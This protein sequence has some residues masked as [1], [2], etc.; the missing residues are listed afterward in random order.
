V[1][2]RRIEPA[3]MRGPEPDRRGG[4]RP[5]PNSPY[6]G[7][8]T[9]N[10]PTEYIERHP[11]TTVQRVAPVQRPPAPP[12]APG[13]PGSSRPQT[14]ATPGHPG[15]PAQR[16]P[17]APAAPAAAEQFLPDPDEQAE[18]APGRRGSHRPPRQS[19]GRLAATAVFV[20]ALVVVGYQAGRRQLWEDEYSSW[21]ASTFGMRDFQWLLDNKDLAL[22][23]FYAF[24]HLWIVVFGDS[25][26]SLRVP[27]VIA[28]ALTAGLL[29]LIGRRILNPVA[30]IAAGVLFAATPTISRYAQESRPYA[31][32]VF[33][34]T[35]ATLLLLRALEN[36]TWARWLIYGLCMVLVGLSHIVAITILGA[37][38]LAVRRAVRTTDV[39]RYWRWLAALIMVIWTIGPFAQYASRQSQ[40]ISWIVVN[41]KT[42][43]HLPLD[44]FGSWLVA[45]AVT[46]LAMLGMARLAPAGNRQQLWL[47]GAW[48]V[49]PPVFTL[50]THSILNLF[51]FRYLL[52]T[53]PAWALLAGAGLDWIGRLI[54]PKSLDRRRTSTVV[55]ALVA[56]VVLPAIGVLSLPAQRTFRHDP[57]DGNPAYRAVAETIEKQAKPDDAVA[58]GGTRWLGRRALAYELRDSSAPR[59]VFLDPGKRQVGAFWAQECPKPVECVGDTKRIWLVNTART[60]DVFADMSAAKAA[61]LKGGFTVKQTWQFP[62]VRLALLLARPGTAKRVTTPADEPTKSKKTAKTKKAKTKA[63]N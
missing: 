9:A 8:G 40:A 58:Y 62:N 24:M 49:V 55:A 17:A 25:A 63:D 56:A 4:P 20:L 22:T 45:G 61:V 53:L 39:L 47:L 19:G 59:D 32:A 31:L 60:G 21:H 52:F 6:R 5:N 1:A 27:S 50:A 7:P 18:G 30:G 14:Y 57:L 33:F 35:L 42:V 54:G 48:A 37:H 15:V 41:E 46:G 16:R 29:V 12:V 34:A 10:A 36:P 11:A 26:I 13:H 3:V 23:P 44:L 43:L 2:G 28:M 51:L 38:F